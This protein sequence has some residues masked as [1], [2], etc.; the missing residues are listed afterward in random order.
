MGR[1]RIS[2]EMK[3]IIE[4]ISI[5]IIVTLAAIGYLNT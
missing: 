2:E 4:T 3:F 1:S 5:A